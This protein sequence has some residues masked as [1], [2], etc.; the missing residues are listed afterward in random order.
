MI[1]S[2][3]V[4][5]LLDTNVVSELRK[6]KPNGNVLAWYEGQRRAEAYIS[7]LVAG[8]IRQGI[9]RVRAR[10][11]VQAEALE[12]WLTGLLTTYQSRV[13]PVTVEVAEA[14]GRLNASPTP[15]PAID[16]LMAATAQ[17]HRL[18]LVSRNVNNV[19]PTVNPFE[20]Q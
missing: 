3:E 13:L 9:E 12:R 8:E 18:T 1:W 11:A 7:T 15:P 19:V 14:W 5:Y 17:V 2:A 4:A 6:P 20:P 10:D 16:G